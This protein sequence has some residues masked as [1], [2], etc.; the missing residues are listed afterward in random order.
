MLKSS[1]KATMGMFLLASLPTS[2]VPANRASSSARGLSLADAICRG[3]N[4]RQRRSEAASYI[5]N[6]DSPPSAPLAS[7][8]FGKVYMIEEVT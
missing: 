4:I 8:S 7:V 3:S 1:S 2:N 5:Q 6:D